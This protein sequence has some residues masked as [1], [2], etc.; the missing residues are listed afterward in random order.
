MEKMTKKAYFEAIDE[1]A[2]FAQTHGYDFDMAAKVKEF[3]AQEIEH[4]ESRTAKARE[5]RAEKREDD[6]LMQDVRDVLTGDFMTGED[7]VAAIG[8]DD[9]TKGK[10]V[11]RLTK[12]VEAGVVEKDEI[13]IETDGGK[14]K[15]KAYRLVTIEE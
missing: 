2:I 5:K 9:V 7:I 13:T 11:T 4:L 6:T 1:I 14:R 15:A 12:L 10:I 3:V 8:R